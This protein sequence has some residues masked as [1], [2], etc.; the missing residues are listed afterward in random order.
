MKEVHLS[1]LKN[2]DKDNYQAFVTY[3]DNKILAT[4]NIMF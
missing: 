1:K 4:I 3:F 2:K